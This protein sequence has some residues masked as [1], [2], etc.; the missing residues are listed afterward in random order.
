MEEIPVLV[1]ILAEADTF[2]QAMI[3]H[4]IVPHRDLAPQKDLAADSLILFK[5]AWAKKLV[6]M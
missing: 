5:I 1:A 4:V 3:H 6:T 2:L